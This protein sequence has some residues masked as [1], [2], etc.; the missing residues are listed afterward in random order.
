MGEFDAEMALDFLRAR[1]PALERGE[2]IEIRALDRAKGGAIVARGFFAT[3]GEAVQYV[4]GLDMGWEIYYGINPR[5]GED[6]TKKGVARALASW[7]D[8]DFKH[9]DND[10]ELAQQSL[11]NFELPPTWLIYS[12]GGYQ[13]YWAIEPLDA[14]TYA[15]PVEALMRALYARLGNLDAVQ[16]LDRIFRLPGTFNNKY[17]KPRRVRV[18]SYEP[19]ARYTLAQMQAHLPA[20]PPKERGAAVGQATK[21][22]DVTYEEVRD[23]LRYIPPTLPYSEYLAVWMA[24]HS[25]F[26]GEEGLRLVDDWSS[27]ARAANGQYSSPRTQPNKHWEFRRSGGGGAIGAGTLY[28]YA[29]RHGWTP[30]PKPV[31]LIKRKQRQAEWRQALDD[32][33]EIDRNTLPYFL[34]RQIDYLG[35]VATPLPFDW[36]ILTA[37]AYYGL[38]ISHIR[39][40]NLHPGL[41]FMGVARSN[42]GKNI[43]TDAI[44]DIWKRVQLRDPFITMTSG[45]PE[46]MWKELDGVGKR[47]L[48]YHREFGGT[49]RTFQRDYMSAARDAYCN[50]YDGADIHHILAKK[51]I[52]ATDPFLTVIATTTPG[53]ISKYMQL[54]DITGGYVN[55]FRVCFADSADLFLEDRP[56]PMVAEALAAELSAHLAEMGKIRAA[57]WDTPRGEVPALWAELLQS[58]GIGTGRIYRVEESVDEVERAIWRELAAVKKTAT[59]LE[60]MERTPQ[61]DNTGTVLLIRESNLRLAILIVMR[62]SAYLRGMETIIAVSADER[63]M[64]KIGRVLRDKGPL[65]K[66]V[67]RAFCHADIRPFDTALSTMIEE[68]RIKEIEPEEGKRAMRYKAAG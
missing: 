45:S 60:A 11:N 54:E 21:P 48:A 51:T 44:Y 40:E 23:L 58:L 56:S 18:I 33:G 8:L 20:L 13:P 27:E 3:P 66:P 39:F 6:G 1:F 35:D 68:G 19:T 62:A 16:N 53:A 59:C 7:A 64:E 31:P 52:H 55:R 15:E 49:L 57:R 14:A 26:P 22:G 38:G 65:P 17:G 30:P 46:G 36:S 9:F 34:S 67:L 5:L 29:Q 10:D 50:L 63:L 47:M 2:R 37:L 24:V 12:G 61:V 25:L 42:A 28:H 32:L 43:V 41:W 4:A